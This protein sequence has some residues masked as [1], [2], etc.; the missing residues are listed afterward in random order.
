MKRKANSTINIEYSS[1]RNGLK[2]YGKKMTVPSI[3]PGDTGFAEPLG[4]LMRE[5]NPEKTHAFYPSKWGYTWMILVSEDQFK[6]I[7]DTNR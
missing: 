4:R 6:F 1:P 7:N 2:V 5:S 3:I